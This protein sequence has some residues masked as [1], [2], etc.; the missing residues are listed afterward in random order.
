[1]AAGE[2][3]AREIPPLHRRPG[4]RGGRL[5][6]PELGSFSA[7]YLPAI[8][9]AGKALGND[10]T[11]APVRTSVDIELAIGE[12]SIT[13][14]EGLVVNP[15]SYT[16]A[17]HALIIALAR[18]YGV[19]A[20]YPYPY[21]AAAGGLVSYGPDV[22]DLFRRSASY[23]DRLLRAEKPADLPVQQPLKYELVVNRK[24]AQALGLN[25]P[26]DLLAAA[27]EVIE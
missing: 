18:Q 25:I 15:D 13:P 8:E 3:A 22:I 17:N 9:A 24:T 21:E 10:T 20:V 26:Q 4:A 7:F 23:V 11:A 14:K 16:Q 1:M 6:H 5:F 2:R 27:D 12:I 19:P